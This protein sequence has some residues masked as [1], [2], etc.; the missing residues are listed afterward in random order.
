M[1]DTNITNNVEAAGNNVLLAVSN[2]PDPTLTWTGMTI[3]SN[4]AT[5]G[6][7]DA[8]AFATGVSLG[9]DTLAANITVDLNDGSETLISVPMFSLVPAVVTTKP[10]DGGFSTVANVSTGGEQSLQPFTDV[11]DVQFGNVL[12]GIDQN[13][14]NTLDR[15]NLASEGLNGTPVVITGPTPLSVAPS[16]ISNPAGA[17]Q[18]GTSTTINAGTDVLPATLYK[19]GDDI[20]AAQTV[21][22]A[23]SG[24]SDIQRFEI[25]FSNNTILQRG[26]IADPT[27]SFYDPSIA[28]N[29]AGE[30]VI[31]FSG[32][33]PQEFASAHA[34]MGTTTSGVTTFTGPNLLKQGVAA[35]SVTTTT[36]SGTSGG[37]AWGNYSQTV[38]DG[39]G[40]TNTFW[41]FQEYAS[42]ATNGPSSTSRSP[43]ACRPNRRR[44]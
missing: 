16:T 25:S 1:L 7:P 20:W 42:G 27:T 34:D 26:L 6:T 13:I 36:I 14:A 35:Y 30:V 37:N 40:N 41:T 11:T 28:A 39:D 31:G 5:S 22:D 10:S 3:A 32:S 18:P 43:S 44:A 2:S 21:Q 9:I 38:P 33:G 15:F 4:T 12:F 19:V 29:A 23:T 8:T 24:K 17:A